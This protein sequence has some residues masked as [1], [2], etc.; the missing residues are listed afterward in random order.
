MLSIQVID[1]Y[2]FIEEILLA[3]VAPRMRQDL[4]L[5]ICASV[6]LLYMLFNLLD[7]VEPLLSNEYQAT[8][9]ANFAKSLLMLSL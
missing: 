7:V 2:E 6:S 4:C 1:K 5:L 3:E 8:F 9:Q